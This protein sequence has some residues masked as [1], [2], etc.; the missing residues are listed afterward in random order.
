MGRGGGVGKGD[1]EDEEGKF[2]KGP[3]LIGERSGS[4][5]G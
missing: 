3:I 2:Y 4:F 5:I 1:K